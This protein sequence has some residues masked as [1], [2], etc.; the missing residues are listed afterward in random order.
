MDPALSL[1][2]ALR[3]TGS[4]RSFA[5]RRVPDAVVHRLLDVARFAPSGGNRQ[6][7]RVV[8][9]K[10]PRQRSALRDLY[11]EA[12]RRYLAMAQA[13]LV[14]WAPVTDTA[15][16][17]AALSQ[18]PGLDLSAFGEAGA[19]ALHLDEV[20]VLLVLLA[21]LGALAASD[22]DLDRYGLVGGASVYPFAW[23]LLLAARAE[24]LAGVLTTMATALEPAVHRVLAVDG[25]F[26][27]A[28]VMALGYPEA[29]PRRL[30]RRPVEAF[31][32][33]DTF[34]GPPLRSGAS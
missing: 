17:T 32:T 9:V 21:D 10:D 34:D 23:S 7:W 24:G 15:R 16:E 11:A 2:E 30:R 6:G 28:A 20:P 5:D 1:T 3:S 13:G 31:A 26:A 18:A 12:A 4:V 27:V 22:R 29:A 14:P 19:L 25:P 33:V 8:V